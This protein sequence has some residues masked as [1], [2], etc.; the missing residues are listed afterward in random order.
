MDTVKQVLTPIFQDINR[1]ETLFRQK[2]R[3]HLSHIPKFKHNSVGNFISYI[4]FRYYQADI[5][6]AFRKESLPIVFS[7]TGNFRNLIE[8][9]KGIIGVSSNP[10]QL[11]N[12]LPGNV[13]NFF[14]SNPS[15]TLP[16]L[17]VNLQQEA[18]QDKEYLRKLIEHGVTHFRINCAFGD[19][20][21]WEKVCQNLKSAAAI[22]GRKVNLLFDMA[23]PKIR[24]EKL[25]QGKS[26]VDAIE[27]SKN[28][29]LVIC[30][31]GA[32]TF[33]VA[34][35]FRDDKIIKSSFRGDFSGCKP[36]EIIRFDDSR[37]EARIVK[38]EKAFVVVS[39]EKVS[40]NLKTLTL[41]KGIN[42]PES[43]LG[44]SGLTKKDKKDLASVIQKDGILCFSF[45]Q[46]AADIISI[47]KEISKHRKPDMPVVIKIETCKA[48]QN[49][50]EII[51]ATMRFPNVALLIARGDLVSECGWAA[52]PAIQEKIGKFARAAHLPVIL[53]TEIMES[54]NQKGIH[55]RPEMID[56]YHARH[57]DCLL[58]NKGPN[59][60]ETVEFVREV[61]FF[62]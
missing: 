5:D 61:M 36:G 38:V 46:S 16:F 52:L 41:G 30:P 60:F 23:G 47:E 31:L 58:L 55:T 8:S 20:L 2:F 44:I 43:N 27:I 17:M 50:E 54:F 29:G 24:I 37:F 14:D 62:Q 45:V 13:S 59:I 10:N 7:D 25:F 4:S 1:Q 53:A 51:L 42:F 9:L 12:P 11:E 35:S 15:D 57:F 19:E 18:E 6:L 48:I 3:E 33:E 26:E 40:Q 39:I 22:V 21:R 32:N 28:E 34:K 49:L 56:L